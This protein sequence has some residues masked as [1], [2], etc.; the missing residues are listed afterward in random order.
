[1]EGYVVLAI[2]TIFALSVV[3]MVAMVLGFFPNF[4]ATFAQAFKVVFS[5]TKPPDPHENEKKQE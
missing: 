4:A 5:V 1:M 3:S 2:V